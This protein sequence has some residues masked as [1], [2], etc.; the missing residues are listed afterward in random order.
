MINETI[1]SWFL[2]SGQTVVSDSLYQ[3][4]KVAPCFSHRPA[5]PFNHLSARPLVH[6]PP[7]ISLETPK[8]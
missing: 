6:L 4:A 2:F 5:N 3:P 8:C 1:K 7:F